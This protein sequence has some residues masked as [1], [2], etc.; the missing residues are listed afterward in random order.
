MIEWIVWA[1]IFGAIL[2]W[3]SKREEEKRKNAA[4]Y[5]YYPVNYYQHPYNQYYN[6]HLYQQQHPATNRARSPLDEVVEKLIRAE[7]ES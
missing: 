2:D 7:N 4:S 6:H 5:N 3:L 1:L